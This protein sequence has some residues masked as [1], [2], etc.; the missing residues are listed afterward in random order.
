[1]TGGVM[2]SMPMSLSL[3]GSVTMMAA[4]MVPSAMPALAHRVAAREGERHRTPLFVAVYIA[5]WA[6]AGI[7]LWQL[8]QQPDPVVAGA[9]VVGAGLYE[10][11][12]LKRECRRR[13]LERAQSGLRFSLN[14]LGS[15]IGLMLVLVAI[16]VM[17]VPLMCAVAAVALMQKLVPPRPAVDLSLALAML[18]TGVAIAAA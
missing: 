11:T 4:M 13:C 7:V 3:V 8:Y 6:L 15:S 16:D 2:A 17:S 18:A 10:L 12:P 1:M 9:L 14:C 5:V